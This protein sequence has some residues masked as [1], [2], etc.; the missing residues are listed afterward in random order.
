VI[1]DHKTQRAGD[2]RSGAPEQ[3]P[4]RVKPDE[5]AGHRG[6]RPSPTTWELHT[7][8]IAGARRV[9]K[10]PDEVADPKKSDEIPARREASGEVRA[11]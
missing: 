4:V 5:N 10:N 7:T 1:E 9:T 8:V 2:T 3:S 11:G 6:D